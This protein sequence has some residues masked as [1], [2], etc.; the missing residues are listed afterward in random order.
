ML[1]LQEISG[2]I[3]A[4]GWLI[5]GVLFTLQYIKIIRTNETKDIYWPTFFGFALL[6]ANSALYGIL[7]GNFWWLPGTG[8]AAVACALIAYKAFRNR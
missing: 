7:T 4:A 2:I 6:N 1:P 3:F 5:S 8:L